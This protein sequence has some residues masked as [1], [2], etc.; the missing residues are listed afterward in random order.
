[1][2]LSVGYWPQI[3]S[4]T[5][6]RI[7]VAVRR[8]SWRELNSWSFSGGLFRVLFNIFCVIQVL[9]MYLVRESLISQKQTNFVMKTH[10]FY[11]CII[12]YFTLYFFTL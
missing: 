4:S 12:T 1:M 10:N 11:F 9:L 2:K 3:A 8:R 7:I 5:D 6:H